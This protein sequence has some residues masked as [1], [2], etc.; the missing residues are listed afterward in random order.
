MKALQLVLKG[1][2]IVSLL[3]LCSAASANIVPLFGDVKDDHFMAKVISVNAQK[4]ILV[5]GDDAGNQTSITVPQNAP[6]LAKAKP[7]DVVESIVTHSVAVDFDTS[8]DKSS[9]IAWASGGEINVASQEPTREAYRQ[10]T[11]QLKIKKINIHKHEITFENLK[12][13]QK[14]VTVVNPVMQARLKEIKANQSILVTITDT[15]DINLISTQ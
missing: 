1:S 8:E 3:T 15:I 4:K 10:L 6:V 2:V 9:P 13:E 7:G 11:A 14:K 5:L 12:G